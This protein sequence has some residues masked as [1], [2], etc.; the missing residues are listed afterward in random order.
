MDSSEQV[1]WPQ[2]GMP[3]FTLFLFKPY[4][5]LIQKN[6]STERKSERQRE[7]CEA[8]LTVVCLVYNIPRCNTSAAFETL[9][10]SILVTS[11]NFPSQI[12]PGLR[13]DTVL[14]TE[15]ERHL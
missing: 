5:T 8:S 4:L 1:G 10:I 7:R 14:R 6:R 11:A 12:F 13:Q 9:P 2:W 15:V 3:V